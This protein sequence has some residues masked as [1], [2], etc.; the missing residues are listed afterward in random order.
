MGGWG[1]EEKKR[2]KT[3]PSVVAKSHRSGAAAWR[4]EAAETKKNEAMCLETSPGRGK[5][6]GCDQGTVTVAEIIII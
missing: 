5:S 4:A 6:R 2:N 3:T 1:G